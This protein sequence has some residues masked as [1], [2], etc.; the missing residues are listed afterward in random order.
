MHG[1]CRYCRHPKSEH[2][3][4]VAR[5]VREDPRLA[6]VRWTTTACSYGNRAHT[7]FATPCACRRYEV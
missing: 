1:Q 3:G 7:A 4:H 5:V 6:G 2:D